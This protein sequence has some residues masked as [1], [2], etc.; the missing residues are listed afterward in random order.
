MWPDHVVF[1]P[2]LGCSRLSIHRGLKLHLLQELVAQAIVRRFDRSILPGT[3]SGHGDCLRPHNRQP[4]HQHLSNELRSIVASSPS[5]RSA[6]ADNTCHDLPNVSSSARL[7]CMR[8]Q[9]LSSIFVHQCEPLEGMS[10]GCSAVDEIAGPDVVLE[11]GR[12]LIDAAIG[13]S[14]RLGAKFPGF[15]QPH[16]PLQP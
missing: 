16:R 8:H 7:A 9:V 10:A 5:W 4:V 6:P 1:P 11:P 3:P 14:P 15:S 13:A 2:V 12:R